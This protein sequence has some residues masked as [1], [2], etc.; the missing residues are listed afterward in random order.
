MPSFLSSAKLA[1]VS[2]ALC[3]TCP[4]AMAGFKPPAS[5]GRS[6]APAAKSA[7]PA[8]K[9]GSA[10]GAAKGTTGAAHGPTT[11]NPGH[12]PT[13]SNPGHGPT[14][15]NPG[16]GPTTT[17][18]GRG[19]T[20]TTAGRTQGSTAS[21]SA[22][23]HSA[24]RGS[25]D[26][27]TASGKDVRMRPGGKLSD[28]HDARR[29]VDV[30]RGLGGDRRAE[31]KRADGSRLVSE[32]GRGGYAERSYRFRGH[33]F[34]RR[35]Y[36]F[37]GRRFDR[38]YRPYLYRGVAIDVYEPDLFYPA[39]FYGWVYN[40]WVAPV[41]FSWGFA[42]NPWYGY[43]GPYFAPQPYYPSA[44]A[45]LADY[46]ISTSLSDAYQARVDAGLPVQPLTAAAPGQAALTADVQAQIAEEVR[47]Q[48]ALENAEAQGA[49][50]GEDPDPQSSGIA[51]IVADGSTHAFVVGD[52][53]DLTSSSGQECLVTA[54][55]VLQ[56]RTP[57]APTA[58][59][60]NLVVLAS[61]G[62]Q[63]CAKSSIV[64]V[65]MDDLQDLQ[66]HMRQTIDEGLGEVQKQEGKGLPKAPASAA[67]PVVKATYIQAAPPA[68]I[69]ISVELAQ[70]DKE[71]DNAEHEANQE[72]LGPAAP[73]ASTASS[74]APV[75][76]AKGQTIA[77]VKVLMG[78]PKNVINAGTKQVYVYPDMKI[79]FAVGKVIDIQ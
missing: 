34:A 30:H 67:A 27:H 25:R 6:A 15:S 23:S 3:L 26:V 42:A 62:G 18:A 49:S 66:N 1:R 10:G 72:A 51:R 41:A 7:S 43:Y 19:A 21:R 9:P 5:S 78:E 44:S 17:T 50:R 52:N 73:G 36:Y 4:I 35:S 69:N 65:A 24:P 14:T 11:S 70:Q 75:E 48:L 37:H 74:V 56:L 45:W 60:A 13:T 55:D 71:A 77:Q 53:M 76:L 39:P 38:F 63:E 12:G 22:I 68:E 59:E 64:T 40:P 46:M 61:K 79:T 33:D 2:L 47:R 58:T 16:R 31:G 8:A 20:T 29:G 57:P 54:G 28:V 32:R